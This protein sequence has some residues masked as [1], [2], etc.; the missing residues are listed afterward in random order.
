MTARRRLAA[1]LV[2]AG[3]VLGAA[4]LWRRRSDVGKEHV[5]VYF[6]DGSMVTFGEGSDE[7]A[8]LLPIARR[9]L[10]HARG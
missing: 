1:L 2:T 8:R 9:A 5:D 7:A 4:A 6:A 3:S 10:A